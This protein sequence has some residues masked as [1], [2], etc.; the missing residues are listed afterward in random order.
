M[1]QETFE[2][3]MKVAEI[4]GNIRETRGL[5]WVIISF[6]CIILTILLA[7]FAVKLVPNSFIQKMSDSSNSSTSGAPAERR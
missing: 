4:Q 7:I 1:K 3:E 5:N 6:A 2:R